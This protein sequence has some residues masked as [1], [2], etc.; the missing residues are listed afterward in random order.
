MVCMYMYH[1][2]QSLSNLTCARGK[3]HFANR[4]HAEAPSREAQ[5]SGGIGLGTVISGHRPWFEAEESKQGKR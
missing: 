1:V 2:E 3:V 4:C 5:G